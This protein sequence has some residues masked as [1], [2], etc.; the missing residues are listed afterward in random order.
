MAAT[1]EPGRLRRGS[2]GRS[3]GPIGASRAP[4]AP[5]W[6]AQHRV[7]VRRPPRR[8][9]HDVI[10]SR[11][12]GSGKA[13]ETRDFTFENLRTSTNR[14]A[15]VLD[16]LNVERGDRVFVLTDRIPELYISVLGTLKHGSV[17]CT[18]FS[19]FGPEP[20]RQ[21]LTIGGGTVLVTTERLYRRK[22]API[23]A[24]LP[25]ARARADRRR[26]G[27]AHVEYPAPSTSRRCSPRP[28]TSS[29]SRPPIPTT[30]RSCTSRAARPAPPRAPSTRTRRCSPTS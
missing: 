8:G 24:A 19:A 12:G 2:Q 10:S 21:R 7:R 6:R 16:A 25:G 30:S 29:T 1:A 23:R 3:R 26:R 17:A 18:L 20:I 9:I 13:G 27:R 4:R 11:S 5:R 15:N 28:T 14:F 22:I